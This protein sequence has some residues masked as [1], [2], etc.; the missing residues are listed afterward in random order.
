[1]STLADG[2]RRACRGM[3]K[4]SIRW[5]TVVKNL[6]R[7]NLSCTATALRPAAEVDSSERA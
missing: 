1:M 2:Q 6:S 7:D 3:W 5:T 4:G